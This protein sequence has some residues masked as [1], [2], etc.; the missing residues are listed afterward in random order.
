[1]KFNILM[2]IEDLIEIENQDFFTHSENSVTYIQ[3]SRK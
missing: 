2:Q 1:M 3:V